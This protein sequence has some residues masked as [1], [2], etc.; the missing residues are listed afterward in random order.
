MSYTL[1]FQKGLRWEVYDFFIWI[2]SIKFFLIIGWDLFTP[3]NNS[4][5]GSHIKRFWMSFAHKLPF[6]FLYKAQEI[7]IWAKV[8]INIIIHLFTWSY[9]KLSVL[10]NC[11][12]WFYWE[13]SEWSDF[14]FLSIGI[15]L[16]LQVSKKLKKWMM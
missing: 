8:C 4:V 12:A 6:S 9:S 2:F 14:C 5:Y 11:E 16:F 3:Q 1:C 7:Y 15:V 13:C 10:Q